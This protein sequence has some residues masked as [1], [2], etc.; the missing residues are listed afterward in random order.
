MDDAVF[1]AAVYTDD[2]QTS[3]GEV[4]I[5]GV[6]F[7][8]LNGTVNELQLARFQGK[9]TFGPY[10][11]DS[12]PL[13]SARVYANFSGGIGN[14]KEV[15]GVDDDTSWDSTLETRYPDGATLLPRTTSYEGTPVGTDAYPLGDFPASD[16][17]LWAAFD[18]SIQYWDETTATFT[19]LAATLDASPVERGVEFEEAFYIPLGSAGYNVLASDEV[20]VDHFTDFQPIHFI[21][22]DRKLMAL[23]RDGV[24]WMKPPG[25]VFAIASTDPLDATLPSGN[26]P[27]KLVNFINQR[28]DPTLHVITNDLVFA[29]DPDGEKLYETRLDYP[30]HPSQGLGATNWRGDTMFVSVGTGIHGYNGST[31]TSM[32]PDGRHGLP[33]RLRGAIVDLAP[34]YNALLALVRG[35]GTEIVEDVDDTFVVHPPMYRERDTYASGIAVTRQVF[36]CILRWSN[37]QWHKVWESPEAAGDPTW[38]VI[39]QADGAYR[40]WWGYAGRMHTQ[41]LPVDFQNPKQGLRSGSMEFESTGFLITGWFDAGMTAFTKLATHMEVNL[42]DVLEGQ[43]EPGGSVT[44]QYQYNTMLSWRTLGVADTV[45]KTVLPFQY[46]LHRSGVNFSDGLAFRRIRFRFV[47]TQKQSPHPDTGVMTND[48]TLSPLMTSA[49]F[50]FIKIPDSQLSWSFT[51][52]LM[53]PNGFKGIGNRDLARMLDRALYS[54]VFTDFEY[55]DEVYRVRVAQTVG[56]RETGYDERGNYQVNLVQVSLGSTRDESTVIK[57]TDQKAS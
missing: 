21:V 13:L 48:I 8:V 46:R 52:P 10:D 12:D 45:G 26:R 20:T 54:S 3:N 27:R 2:P 50:K 43:D 35:T 38:M 49:V 34:E 39:S 36:S 55:L 25:G 9:V 56:D 15:A 14:E 5:G 1:E 51:V 29:W 40:L 6:E 4:R 16:P 7:P 33:S 47:Y 32:G 57:Y 28:G 17:K 37:S 11:L 44:V 22:W 23:T 19:A 24:I 18:D 30:E 53:D 41:K 42:E 31:I